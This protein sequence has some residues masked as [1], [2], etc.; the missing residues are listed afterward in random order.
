[1]NA[2]SFSNLN[3]STLC[4]VPRDRVPVHC[5]YFCMLSCIWSARTR[6]YPLRGSFAWT[7]Y[8]SVRT[9]P[10]MSSS[11]CSVSPVSGLFGMRTTRLYVGCTFVHWLLPFVVDLAFE[12]L[13][14]C[15]GF[16]FD[17]VV[18]CL[19][20]RSLWIYGDGGD[21]CACDENEIHEVINCRR[22]WRQW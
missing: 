5:M 12:L 7:L 8:W 4:T 11:D 3:L 18:P 22:R 15:F 14:I 21:F 9:A 1:M 16:A 17:L 13:L 20:K 10:V 2:D 6:A 19:G